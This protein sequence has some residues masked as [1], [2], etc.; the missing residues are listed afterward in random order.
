MP[1]LFRDISSVY[2]IIKVFFFTFKKNSFH[3]QNL[4][5]RDIILFYM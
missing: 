1:Q 5:D 4:I 2:N 3:E